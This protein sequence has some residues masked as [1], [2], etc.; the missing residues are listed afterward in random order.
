[1]AMTRLDW[2]TLWDRLRT[3]IEGG[4]TSL[5]KNQILAL[6]DRLERE[7]VREAEKNRDCADDEER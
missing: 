7:M 6:M 4:N 1:M 5:G 2:L 3:E